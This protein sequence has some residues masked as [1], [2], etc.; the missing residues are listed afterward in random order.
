MRIA[1][2]GA[3]AIGT[4]LGVRLANAGQQVS[5]LA[6][7]ETLAAVRQQGLRLVIGGAT[8]AATVA[9]SDR[10]SDLG[11]QDLV[12]L[13]VKGQA[14]A[15]RG[16]VGR[17]FAGKRNNDSVGDEWRAVVVLSRFAWWRVRPHR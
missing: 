9:V 13:A 8:R 11:E 5:V 7:G 1:I 3:G 12:V 10:A 14:L 4:W 17:G 2:V 6:R 16:G 15:E